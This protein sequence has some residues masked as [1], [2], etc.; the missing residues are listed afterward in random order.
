MDRIAQSQMVHEGRWLQVWGN[1]RRVDTQGIRGCKRRS[2]C[3]AVN[4]IVALF[5][6]GRW[7][8]CLLLCVTAP[9]TR[10][11][12]SQARIY[13]AYFYVSLFDNTPAL[14]CATRYLYSMWQL[15]WKLEW[16]LE[17][18]L[19]FC[20]SLI[21]NIISQ[22][23][24]SFAAYGSYQIATSILPLSI[25]FNTPGNSWFF[26]NSRR[27]YSSIKSKDGYHT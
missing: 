14:N 12:L 17:W 7:T 5:C 1:M 13:F 4:P 11:V 16:Q 26:S 8:M 15:E 22:L 19:L 21:I 27:T 23:R 18:Q 25:I 9:S 3:C 2:F 24:I 6:R 10:A 20:N